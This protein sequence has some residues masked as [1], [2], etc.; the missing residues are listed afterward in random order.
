MIRNADKYDVDSI[1]RRE[2]E[3]RTL[4][5]KHKNDRQVYSEKFKDANE[6]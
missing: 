3:I 4:A 6:S 1:S 5:S 2:Y